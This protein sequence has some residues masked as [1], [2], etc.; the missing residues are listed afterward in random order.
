MLWLT[1]IRSHSMAP[2]L[3][4]GSLA[5]TRSLGRST[6]IRRGDLVIVDARASGEPM[7]KRI[8]GLPGEVVAIRAGRVSIDGRALAEPYASPSVFSDTYRVPP[9]HYFLL[10]DNRDASSDGRTWRNP[11]VPREALLGR[12]LGRPWTRQTQQLTHSRQR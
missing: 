4:D 6:P 7:V 2:T 8:V 5:L 11:Y 12:I 10:G 1:R 3:R 9:G